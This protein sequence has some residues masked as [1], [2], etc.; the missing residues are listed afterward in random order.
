VEN[1]IAGSP[2][3]AAELAA[4]EESLGLFAAGL[5]PISPPPAVKK[6][7]MESVSAGAERFAP[8]F[9]TMA[10]VFQLGR[11]A[12]RGVV[13]RAQDLA[14][15]EPG[16]FPG[17]S[18][19]HFDGGPA[20]AAVDCGL[21]KFAPGFEHPWHRHLGREVIVVL[22]GSQTDSDGQVFRSGDLIVKEPGTS[23]AYRV[24]DGEEYVFAVALYEALEI[25]LTEEMKP[26]ESF[27]LAGP[28]TQDR[29]RTR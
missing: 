27:M 23:H 17:S 7:L 19:F 29:A 12:M 1:A 6:R 9:D 8:F 26:G 14:Q 21:V 2:D 10:K 16:P 4:A 25:F 28:K 5:D 22:Q 24:H 3:L 13:E 11:D 18:L 15:W 20:M